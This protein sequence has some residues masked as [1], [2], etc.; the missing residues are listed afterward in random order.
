MKITAD[1]TRK[2]PSHRTLWR[3]LTILL[4]LGT[5]LV[6]LNSLANLIS[7]NTHELSSKGNLS[8]LGL[9]IHN[10]HDHHGDLP[11]DI[12]SDTGQPLLSWR[13]QILP[14]IE[15]EDLYRQFKLNEPW[16]SPHNI[17]FLS[18]IPSNFNTNK[19]VRNHTHPTGF[20][21][22]RGFSHKGA[23]F[24]PR[25]PTNGERSKLTFDQFSDGLENTILLVEAADGIEWTRPGEL[26]GSAAVDFPIMGF[27][28]RHFAVKNEFTVLF[29]NGKYRHLDRD[30]PSQKLRSMTTYAGGEKIPK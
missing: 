25:I 8:Q 23:V 17:Q 10:Y 12:Y 13:V 9:A 2:P 1:Q 18:K 16:D 26:N 3:F 22:F 24:A 21:H 14:F 5:I 30:E 6:A 27:R 28:D 7:I 19:H 4:V 11:N 29:A 15:G 20:T